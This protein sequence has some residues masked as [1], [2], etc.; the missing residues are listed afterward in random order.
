MNKSNLP[1]RKNKQ[2]WDSQ[3]YLSVNQVQQR[4]VFHQKLHR[5]AAT[6]TPARL[7]PKSLLTFFSIATKKN[8]NGQYRRR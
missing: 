5:L 6:L 7:R 4:R 3:G 2:I 8:R 1:S